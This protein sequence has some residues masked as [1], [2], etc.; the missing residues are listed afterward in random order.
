MRRTSL[1]LAFVLV[2]LFLGP[3]SIKAQS[4]PGSPTTVTVVATAV[5]LQV[6]WS[7]PTELGG[8]A[9]TA[10]HVR[11][12]ES[13]ADATNDDN[14]T[15]AIAW[16][17]GGGDL[18]YTIEGL[19]DST[20]YKVGVQAVN[21]Q[22]PSLWTDP[23]T[24]ST[25]DHGRYFSQATPLPVGG[26][27]RGQIDTGDEGDLF[28]VTLPAA[29]RYWVF[30]TGELD[31]QGTLWDVYG[32]GTQTDG[33][34]PRDM[35]QFSIMRGYEG[36]TNHILVEAEVGGATGT[37]TIHLRSVADPGD[38]KLAA[39]EVTLGQATGAILRVP[40]EV[41]YFRFTLT[42]TTDV[43]IE[44]AGW[45]HTRAQLLEEDETEIAAAQ[46]GYIARP[47]HDDNYF[48]GFMMRRTL[49]P[50]SYLLKVS[51]VPEVV[52][53]FLDPVSPTGVYFLLI[54][55]PADPGSSRATATPLALRHTVAGRISSASD[56][57]YYSLT[58]DKE[59]YVTITAV[60]YG[61]SF[62]LVPTFFDADGTDLNAYVIRRE[63]YGYEG[64][65]EAFAIVTQVDAGT[66][67]VR[68]K[69]P[70]GGT[71]GPYVLSAW[72]T[73]YGQDPVKR[74]SDIPTPQ[75]D[76]L[77][78][79]QW[80][81]KNTRQLE[82][83][84]SED[85]NVEGVWETNK[86]EGI[87]VAVVDTMVQP[88]H[89][90]LV[91]TPDDPLDPD[92]DELGRFDTAR[93]HDYY[94]RGLETFE[95]HGTNVAGLIAARANDIGVRGVAPEATIYSFNLLAQDS[96]D[97]Q[98]ADAFT[99][100]MDV[101]AISNHSYGSVNGGTPSA[102]PGVWRMAVERAVTDGYDGKGVFITWAA[103]NDGDYG[104][105]AS[106]DER[107][108]SYAVT[109]VCAIDILDQRPVWSTRGPNLWI[110]A[111]G[112]DLTSTITANRYTRRF[113]GTSGATPIV[114]G[115]AALV[116]AANPDLTW[117]DVKLI[118]AN[119]ARKNH[120][121]H[122]RLAGALKYGSTS[123]RYSFSYDYGFGAVD[124][125]A[126]V[127]LAK[128]WTDLPTPLRKLEVSSGPLNIAI[129][130]ATHDSNF[131]NIVGKEIS[132]SLKADSN[133]IEFIEFIELEVSITHTQA[134]SLFIQLDS[135]STT[136][137]EITVPYFGEGRGLNIFD[138]LLGINWAA[139]LAD[140]VNPFTF[141]TARHLGEGAAGEWT[142][143]IRDDDAVLAG[144]LHSWK[145]TF[146]GHGYRPGFPTLR[147]RDNRERI[148]INFDPPEDTGA[149][150]I[151]SYDLR[152]IRANV[153]D[154]SDES[155]WTV[156]T[157]FP[158]ANNVGHNYL[159]GLLPGR[160]YDLQIRAVNATG[161]GPW[162]AASRAGQLPEPPRAPAI[163]GIV[164]RDRG[165]G[166][167]WSAPEENGGTFINSYDL[168][169]NAGN[170][171]EFR[172]VWRSGDGDLTARIS[173]LTNNVS[174]DVQ[175]RAR[176]GIGEGPWS[177]AVVTGTPAVQ[178]QAPSFPPA[179]TG[180]RAIPEGP[181]VGR[182]V[183]APVSAVDP[184]AGEPLTYFLAS[185]D[186]FFR[187]DSN[188]GQLLTRKALDHE[189]V[190]SHVLRV[191]VSDSKNSSDDADTM[192]DD[193]IEV[194]VT[195]EDVNEAPEVMGETSVARDENSDLPIDVYQA[196]D[197]EGGATSWVELLGADGG[198]FE[199]DES[200]ELSF[201]APP[202]FEARA[203]SG[204]DNVYN[205]IVR[206]SDDGT[207]PLIGE[208][209]VTVTVTPV[210]ERPVVSGPASIADYP[211]NS[212]ERVGDYTKADP[213]GR[214][215]TWLSLM[216]ADALLFTIDEFGELTFA[217]PPDFE[218]R[219]NNV[220]NVIVRASDDGTPPLIGSLA[221]TVTVTP[222]DEPPVIDGEAAHTIEE[223]SLERVGRY[224]KAD[225][226]GRATSWLSLMGADALLFTIDEFGELTFAEPPD[227]EARTDNVYNVIV[228]AS[229]DGTPPL[230]GSLAVT[231]TVTPVD[232]PPV[233]TGDPAPSI[234]EGGTLLVG[235]YRATDPED[236]T[237]AWQPLAG[238]D[239]DKFEFTP[240]NGRLA[241]K[242][243]P[244]FED[245]DRGGDNEYSLTLGVSDGGDTTPFDV[246]VT[247]TNKEEPGT[248]ALP[249]TQP[250]ADADYTAT[251]SDPDGVQSTTW[252]WERSTSRS[253]PW[254]D[255]TGAFDRTT[256]SVYAPAAGDVGYYLRATA[257][258][259]DGHGPDKS[260]VAVSTNSVLAAPVV[261]NPP[262]FTETNPTRSIAEN[263]QAD[264]L[265]G[266]RVT[267]TDP[268]QGNTVRYEFAL[269]VPTLFT[270]DGGSGQIRVKTAETLDYETAPSHTVTVK[271]LDSSNASDT[272][273][274]TIEVTDV[275]E[276]PVVRRRSG[277]GAFSIVENSGTDVGRFVATDPERRV[278]T[279]SLATSGDHGRFEIEANGALSFKE[280]PDFESDDLGLDKAYTVTVQATEQDGG[281][282]LTG[283][284]AVTVAVT[285][286]NEPP[287]ISGPVVVDFT[288]NG[289]GSVAMYS[290]TDP[291][292]DAT[293]A[294][295]LAGA[296]G[297][298]FA[299]TD[300]VLTFIDPPDYDMPTDRS[301][302]NNEYL[303]TVQ[304]YDGANRVTRPVTVR[305][306]DVN[307]A[308]TVS[309]DLTH[310]VAENST[311]VAT[312][313]ATDPERATITWSV[314]DPGASDF[315]IT[316]AGALSFASAPNYEVESSY[317]VTVRASD[318]TNPVDVDVT[319]TV[320][321]V[322]EDEEL[323]FSALRPLIGAD[324]TAAFKEGMGDAVQSPTWVWARSMSRSGSGT[325]IIG[326]TAAT[327]RPVG[328][329]RNHYLRVTASYNDGH[330]QGTKTLSATS[331]LPTLPDIPNNMPP[332][333]PNPLFAG[334]ATGLSVDENATART[335]VG[336]APQATDPEASPLV[337]SLAVTGFTSD[338]P[339]EINATSRQIRVATGAELNHEDQDRYSV[340]VTAQDEYNATKT[341]TFDI[342]V[343]DV[344]ERPMAVPDMPSTS[345]GAEV[346]FEV[347]GNDSDPD[348]GD[349]LTATIAS[350]PATNLGSVALDPDTYM[351]TYRPP[352]SDFNRTATF[353]YTAS[354]GELSSLPALVT[355]T[356][357]PVNDAPTFPAA[358]AE[359]TVSEQ[360]KAGDPVG[361][362]VVATDVDGD[363]LNYRLGGVDADS[364]EIDEFTG[365][366]STSDQAR[367][368][369]GA[370]D[371]Y[372]VT[373]TADDR[374]GET[375][376]VEVTITVTAGPVV[377]ITGGGG[378]GGGGGGPSPSE[379][380]FEWTVQHD[381]AELDGGNDRATGMWSDGTTLW[382]AD[383]ADG[384]GDAV[385]AYDL[386]SG[387]RVEEREFDLAEA[388]RAPR[389]IWSDRSV[390]WVSDSGQ[391]RLFAYD[392]ATGERL[393]ERE[394]ALAERN[395]D[396]RGI[397]SDEETMWVLDSRA[398]A[399]FAYGF[400]SGELLA[401]YELDSA[402]DDPRGIWSDGVTIWVADH[403]AKRLI[404]YRLPV[405]PDAETGSGEEDADDD[406]RE[407]ERVS[408]EEF[409]EL[410]KASNN[411]PRGIWSDGDV[412]YVADESDDRVY[413]Y[414][415]PNA[416]DA[417]LASLTL[418]GVD[419]GEF[420]PGRTDYE[421]VVAD[422]VT[423]TT[424]EAEAMRRRADVAIDPPDADGDD[425]NG[426]QVALE[427]LGEITVTVTSADDSRTRVYRVQFPETAW[428][429]ASDPW[430]HCLRGAVSEGFSLVVF[431]GGSV[432]ELVSCAETRDIVTLYMLHEGVF[433]SYILG[434][435][436]FVN[437]GFVEL[438]PDGLPPITP[439]IV[440]SNGPPSADPFADL[441]DGGQQPWPECLRGAV[442]E[443]FSLVVYEGGS[444]D[445]LEACAQSRDV[446][447]L[448]ALSD[449]VFVS[450]ILGAPDFVTQPFRDLFA[451]GL[452]LMTP[453]V[454]RSE[455]QPGGR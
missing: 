289:D 362:P 16:V 441:E 435:P 293:Q 383:N 255:V 174:H 437:A 60:P 8:S 196:T 278:V 54:E 137:S 18:A 294:W 175:V 166:V 413:T 363:P 49:S 454:A 388:N 63:E 218:A 428:D 280:A 390:V 271:A 136:T 62:P 367:L 339:F 290:A 340:T 321:D 258:Y 69:A 312:Y 208:L 15:V 58:V 229:D 95:P 42:E 288:E 178:N 117:R 120:P 300:G 434:A 282:P 351:V 65:R 161:A 228:R 338:A 181:L 170:W 332:V 111:P 187:I 131:N 155:L 455:G 308:P 59:A 3:G 99:R 176:N 83:G 144:T 331:T 145:L 421:A 442:S 347:L 219:T 88:N 139:R 40:G 257:A 153:P 379:A 102:V 119:S 448:Y 112:H 337:Y 386:A 84:A 14:W 81:L 269:P 245:A 330:G 306:L 234:E 97:A 184:D 316:N 47:S 252:T 414:N 249:T 430:P 276:R 92:D 227:F 326:A 183:G 354:D 391:E 334:G 71:G 286:V 199:L 162:S 45:V 315:T 372:T 17:T 177:T 449:G 322:D 415:M 24:S 129:P 79:C 275:N 371:T 301:L 163:G 209:A 152:Y 411:S 270:I 405:L 203:D 262:A 223:N 248:L 75:S 450:N 305:V 325:D 127:A 310:S 86:G 261:N 336:L 240:S 264:A 376:M 93:S 2:G 215:T 250:Q 28:E 35:R 291:D 171:R 5:T 368:N 447:A 148:R 225:P 121:S 323:K 38:T 207:P 72:D 439:L 374:Q 6:T 267:A 299:I 233:I 287:T 401:E 98:R 190:P 422:D 77:Y 253:G 39:Q 44:S 429:P 265:V 373:V 23:L 232:E 243:A 359:R 80:H 266:G 254:A 154:K 195:V 230:I 244:D 101:T 185:G 48:Q 197:P 365:Q 284:L 11:H 193:F 33:H 52:F 141:G 443:G 36:G 30:T 116:R 26:S 157:G 167:T 358:P 412:M 400:E 364:F 382:V 408:D 106:L 85:I 194:T 377:I 122:T 432:A 281:D 333:F 57:D 285:N 182:N 201:A 343:E 142:L 318:G 211:E 398:G 419:I 147:T 222:V 369:A 200:G 438:F 9:V 247:V 202:D 179:E 212:L 12:I 50:G 396:A 353:T 319:V 53:G 335:V 56:E 384:A 304:V 105:W 173:G 348:D 272:V 103:G 90:D 341:A 395:S 188:T 7:A 403:G 404:A 132:T 124:A 342:T 100:H 349:T 66:Y 311:A 425:A 180:A 46:G 138:V 37:Y 160:R 345:E 114:A 126:A 344:N 125:G 309:G 226:E 394:F 427:D 313:T 273:Q 87:N 352:D 123:E 96:T 385:Y 417:R 241:F 279:W 158:D 27:L 151:T 109:A 296:D 149:T 204:R 73:Q 328:D 115:V 217:E 292:V 297:G 370:G 242:A 452:P 4:V 221:V 68:V 236:A 380:D 214:A 78:G 41:D 426:H 130:D 440:G 393:E 89:E 31:T 260:L 156:V 314:E 407:L 320:T 70:D 113:G 67:Y 268:D 237:I 29:G 259:T 410:S 303:V 231:V 107:T 298:D 361:A 327:Y 140:M 375:A 433:V 235:T 64:R 238:S 192:V 206:A 381:I 104:G 143:R 191:D 366:L 420:D 76:P 135:P 213:E 128:N 446:A 409:T 82:I 146:Y 186:E 416:I 387:E 43:A 25:P 189:A 118:L 453:L 277:T 329:D 134:R 324:Y 21:D 150:P 205:V 169:A 172:N 402:N 263:A 431:E 61:T 22:G 210:D 91:G 295:S 283:R 168:R 216:G 356:V 165:L 19:L 302:P 445:E 256:T 13:A 74:C 20:S 51:S 220:Y 451:D 378:G 350:R 436:D 355:V 397:W 110:C 399:L 108:T 198:H 159:R 360:A 423:E 424:V 357:D 274:V 55:E 392:L 133:F 94:D 10:Y 164:P 251:L 34:T 389:G 1:V 317:T 239:A 224:T 246:E 406:A 307:E 32:V 346:T 444:V 418:S